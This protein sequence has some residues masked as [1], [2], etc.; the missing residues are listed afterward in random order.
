MKS[1][2]WG[3]RVTKTANRTA[4][5][6]DTS[7]ESTKAKTGRSGGTEE[8][9]RTTQKGP[10]RTAIAPV[11]IVRG[12]LRRNGQG[13]D[14]PS[15]RPESEIALQSP[16]HLRDISVKKRKSP[17]RALSKMRGSETRRSSACNTQRSESGISTKYPL[18]SERQ[19]VLSCCVLVTGTMDGCI[20]YKCLRMATCL[21]SAK[22][23][24]VVLSEFQSRSSYSVPR[25]HG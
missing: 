3:D 4:V 7:T 6:G 18:M 9:R 2:A 16:R 1:T 12:L 8:E 21:G 17:S 15:A 5:G 13:P 11:D 20:M 14:L 22:V 25:S 23:D 10:G 19:I 24:L